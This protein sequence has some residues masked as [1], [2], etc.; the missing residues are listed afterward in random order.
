MRNICDLNLSSKNYSQSNLVLNPLLIKNLRCRQ[1][2][3]KSL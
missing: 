3:L 1:S 2:I